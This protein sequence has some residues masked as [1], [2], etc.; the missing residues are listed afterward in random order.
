MG[1]W[2]ELEKR[3]VENEEKWG[4]LGKGRKM[5]RRG[6]IQKMENEE[7]ECGEVETSIK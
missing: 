2:D 5:G 4:E 1:E 6:G 3:K 7:R